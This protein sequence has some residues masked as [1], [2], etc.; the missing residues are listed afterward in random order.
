G[1]GAARAWRA[2]A[3]GRGRRRGRERS[4]SLPDRH[5]VLVMYEDREAQAQNVRA[6]AVLGRIND[7]AEN[8]ARFEFVAGADVAAWSGWPAKRHGLADL[9]AIAARENTPLFADW[10]AAVRQRWGLKRHRSVLVLAGS[11]GRV[12]FAGEGPLT[13]AQ[14]AALVDALRAL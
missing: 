10:T 14:L 13:E 7:R 4:R 12:L 6:R 5:P 2:A 9:R 1:G 3:G 8:R 11:D